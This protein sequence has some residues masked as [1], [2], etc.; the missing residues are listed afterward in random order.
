MKKSKRIILIIE[1]LTVCTLFFIGFTIFKITKHKNEIPFSLNGSYYSFKV[2]FVDKGLN[3]NTETEKNQTKLKKDI[4]NIISK[5]DNIILIKQSI[6]LDIISIHDPSGYYSN[7]NTTE[8]YFLKEDFFN[9]NSKIMVNKNS[10][11]N[12]LITNDKLYVLGRNSDVISTYSSNYVLNKNN[13]YLI[14]P[15]IDDI[16]LRGTYYLKNY[17]EKLI[18]EVISIFESNNYKISN[19]IKRNETSRISIKDIFSDIEAKSMIPSLF[20]VLFANF[21]FFC[22]LFLRNK[23]TINIYYTFGARSKSIYLYMLKEIRNTLFLG[24]II[25]A[26]LGTLLVWVIY[27]EVNILFTILSIFINLSILV[28]LMFVSL[29]YM[30][31]KIVVEG[32]K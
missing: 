22:M 15:L 13:N 17:D 23:R 26:C 1:V 32:M 14:Q 10:L 21:V 4:L 6:Y 29:I 19:L 28:I 2:D 24:D 5:Y 11:Y 3:S 12:K 20:I 18:T 30:K 9:N 16:D 31:S 8:K 7:F 25:G 27:N